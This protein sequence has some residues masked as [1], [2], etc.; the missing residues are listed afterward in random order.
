[1]A[2]S[3][4]QL[5]ESDE[6]YKKLKAERRYARVMIDT[7]IF[8]NFFKFGSHH[9]KAEGLPEDALFMGAYQTVQEMALSFV[10]AHESFEPVP[11]GCEVPRLHVTL[12]TIRCGETPDA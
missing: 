5:R 8:G 11:M 4:K 7:D 12:Y 1:M 6:R 3:I 9:Y 10:Y 2:K